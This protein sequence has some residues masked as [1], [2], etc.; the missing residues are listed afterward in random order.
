MTKPVDREGRDTALAR[1][2]ARIDYLKRAR[3]AAALLYKRLRRPISVD[4]VRAV[5]PPPEDI[6]PRVMGA[7]FHRNWWTPVGVTMVGKHAHARSIRTFVPNIESHWFK[8]PK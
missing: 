6:D 2:E 8:K 1:L 4:D 3:N 5:V 7:I